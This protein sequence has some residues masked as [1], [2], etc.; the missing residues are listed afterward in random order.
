MAQ[1]CRGV[2]NRMTTNP[3]SGLDDTPCKDHRTWGD[4][5]AGGHPG[6]RV[7]QCREAGASQF[8]SNPGAGP[9]VANGYQQFIATIQSA[10]G[11]KSTGCHRNIKHCFPP[12]AFIL[13]KKT[14]NLPT[15]STRRFKAFSRVA[16]RANNG[17]AAHER[18]PWFKAFAPGSMANWMVDERRS[19]HIASP[20]SKVAITGQPV[21]LAS[22]CHNR[23]PEF[24]GNPATPDSRISAS[25]STARA[26]CSRSPC[27][28][29]R[30]RPSRPVVPRRAGPRCAGR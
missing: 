24:N 22:G 15:R 19:S 3:A 29:D 12:A 13:V 23:E 17:N 7:H 1:R 25:C 21:R 16:A 6:E 14:R 20:V 11:L 28:W 30:R 10:D 27:R 5:G 2:Q 26:G 4:L 18:S 9:V 8:R